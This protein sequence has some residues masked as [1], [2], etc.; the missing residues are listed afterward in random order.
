MEDAALLIYKKQRDRMCARLLRWQDVA[1]LE[2][3]KLIPMDYEQYD[4]WSENCEV[5]AIWNSKHHELTVTD[6]FGYFFAYSDAIF[7]GYSN[8]ADIVFIAYR[9]SRI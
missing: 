4:W 9:S 3:S 7:R 8:L 5:F 2:H 1:P 6:S